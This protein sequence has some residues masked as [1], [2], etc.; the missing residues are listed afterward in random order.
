MKC[1]KLNSRS[2]NT[3]FQV[4]IV[5]AITGINTFTKLYASRN[6]YVYIYILISETLNLIVI[7]MTMHITYLNSL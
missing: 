3:L 5:N 6:K 2:L 4:T 7:L 1:E